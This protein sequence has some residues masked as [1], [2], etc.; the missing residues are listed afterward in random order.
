MEMVTCS[1]LAATARVAGSTLLAIVTFARLN[2][3]PSRADRTTGRI[4]FV[5]RPNFDRCPQSLAG[6]RAEWFYPTTSHYPDKWCSWRGE[7]YSGGFPEG[8]EA[9]TLRRVKT[10]VPPLQ[11]KLLKV[12]NPK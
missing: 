1:I 2:A 3:Q 7:G 5:N 6:Y 11:F 9:A 10:R 4:A 12:E 8:L